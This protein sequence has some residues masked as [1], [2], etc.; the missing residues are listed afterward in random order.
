MARVLTN[1]TALAYAIESS[2]GVLPGSPAWK[3]L[4]PNGI[5]SFGAEITTVARSP[6]SKNR[7]RRKGTVVDLDSSLE[8]E[9][10]A[11]MDAMIDFL[12]GFLM[13]TAVNSDLT[14]RAAD[15]GASGWTI[16]AATAAQAGK[17]QWTSGGPLTLVYASGYA[18]TA[19]NGIFALT[20]DT[21]T[22]GTLLA[23]TGLTSETAPTNA[24][25]SVCG[26]RCEAGDLAVSVS[27]G[28]A[29]LTSGNNSATNDVDFTTLGL[30]VGQRIH[31]GG[32]TSANRFYGAGPVI[33]YGSG[34]IRT[35]AAGT[36]TLDKLDAT[37]ITSDGT[38]TGAGGTLMPVDLLFG[39]FIRNVAVDNAAYLERY[40]QFEL[41]YPN[42]F[43]T[44]P[45]TP[46][47]QPDG[48]E[49][50][51]GNL[52]NSMSW[53]MPLADKATVTFGFVGLDTDA[54]VD[55]GSRRTNA[56]TPR[57][58]LFTGALN[59]S[60]DF[61]RLRIAATDDSGI[62]TDFKDVTVTF[63]NNVS[64]EKVLGRLGARFMN[65]GNFDV[66]IEATAL[67]TDSD[68][69]AAVRGNTTVTM[70]WLLSNDDGALHVDIPSMTIGGGA[71]EFPVN[72]S[73]RI[74]MECQAFQDS[75]FGTSVGV[76]LFPVYPS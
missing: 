66:D 35:I 58:P 71:R 6:I 20:A 12:E 25:L 11:T 24:E 44:D 54:P 4:E 64:P 51:E 76:S 49:Y 17:I 15:A 38:S 1:T 69:A 63:N 26:I 45:P 13:A 21:A 10:D 2:Q 34:R 14:F 73:V 46:V 61:L 48:Y 68:V 19:N 74:A 60:S 70:D 5:N 7:Q 42:L 30:T 59:T 37:L 57:A 72:E 8:Y 23:R 18:T 43:E 56:S 29:T 52:A 39:R 47:A 16:P 65:I 55:G 75:F 62:T 33:S 36:V 27:A 31:V 50:A 41:E 9:A 40:F 32:L 67:F 53:S 22:S 28:V 3:S